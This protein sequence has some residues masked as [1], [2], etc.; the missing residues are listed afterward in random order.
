MDYRA[1]LDKPLQLQV[2]II[3]EIYATTEGVSKKALLAKYQL[4]QPTLK[5]YLDEINH[6]FAAHFTDQLTINEHD[7]RLN[8]SKGPSIGL[9]NII[10]A[11]LRNADAF[12][13]LLFLQHR[14]KFTYSALEEQLAI[15]TT[16]LYRKIA[17]LNQCLAEFALTIQ[18]GRMHGSELQICYF[19]YQLDMQL[20]PFE[21]LIG[22]MAAPQILSIIT[23]LE[24]ALHLTFSIEA[25]TKFYTWMQIV[26]TR[27]KTATKRRFEHAPSLHRALLGAPFYQR[28]ASALTTIVHH[29]ALDWQQEDTAALY[30]A[31]FCFSFLPDSASCYLEWQHV[32]Q[33]DALPIGDTL[34]LTAN[35]LTTRYPM[36][37]VP[38]EDFQKI[39]FFLLQSV[40][41]YTFF[42]GFIYPYSDEQLESEIDQQAS[43]E[44][45]AH[46]TAY[47]AAIAPLWA[48]ITFTS[49][50]PLYRNLFY[51][52]QAAFRYT[53]FITD[54]PLK[55]GLRFF[56]D[57]LIQELF[58][59]MWSRKLNSDCPV[60]LEFFRPQ[61]DYDLIITDYLLPTDEKARYYLISDFDNENDILG[62]KRMLAT[63][64]AM[65]KH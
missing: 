20:I 53:D 37:A 63:R 11:Y 47:L 54:P 29:H 50:N 41:H 62:I 36:A 45:V 17:E 21:D 60:E 56:T 57:L 22:E 24:E 52:V 26:A 3:R 42:Q 48:P 5:A 10:Y 30:L 28:F 38:L 55:V 59:A 12:K 19:Y 43:K 51:R 14:G 65:R 46:A 1:L 35:F 39:R 40:L 61:T 9:P 34:L 31:T 15:S 13:I 18:N 64:Y 27:I 4:S 8:M 6:F 49:Q 32:P 44:F 2:Q 23:D 58:L 33:T 7:G 16:T 25:R